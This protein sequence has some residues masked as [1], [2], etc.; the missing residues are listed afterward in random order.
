MTE[1]KVTSPREKE[2]GMVVMVEIKRE[3]QVGE[4]HQEMTKVLKMFERKDGNKS[5]D[6]KYQKEE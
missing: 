2:T 3:V 4:E 1:S 5:G 6:E